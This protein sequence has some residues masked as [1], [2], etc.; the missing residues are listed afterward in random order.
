MTLTKKFAI[1]IISNFIAKEMDNLGVETALRNY[2]DFLVGKKKLVLKAPAYIDSRLSYEKGTVEEI[3]RER[4]IRN[5]KEADAL[6][7]VRYAITSILGWTPEEAFHYLDETTMKSLKLDYVSKY[8]EFPKHINP[9]KDFWWIVYKA[10]PTQ[11]KYN[12]NEL[13]LDMYKKVVKRELKHFPKMIFEG[14]EG[15][16][17]LHL[18]LHYYI[19]SNIPANSIEDLYEAFGKRTEMIRKLKE[20]QLYYAYKNKFATP[21]DWLH[22]SLGEDGDNFQYRFHQYMDIFKTVTASKKLNVKMTTSVRKSKKK[23]G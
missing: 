13:I 10:F 15:I 2:E 23:K 18:V 22:D 12:P 9:K 4:D 5:S 11:I 16:E 14:G 8:I 6:A 17:R 7:I 3:D 1:L 19:T 20:A 21:L